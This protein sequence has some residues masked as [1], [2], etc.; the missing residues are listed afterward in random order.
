M[1]EVVARITCI[2]HKN[3]NKKHTQQKDKEQR[4]FIPP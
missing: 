1:I 4:Y 3:K 2:T